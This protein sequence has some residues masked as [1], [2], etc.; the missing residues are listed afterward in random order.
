MPRVPE[1]YDDLE[2][3][4]K[5]PAPFTRE[6]TVG[7]AS[8]RLYLGDVNAK[9]FD[10]ALQEWIDHAE[11]VNARRVTGG[12]TTPKRAASTSSASSTRDV[13][14]REQTARIRE[15]AQQQEFDPPVSDNGRLR[16][17][18]IKAYFASHPDDTPVNPAHAAI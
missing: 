12:G 9:R 17:E 1:D 13:L 7:G 2:W 3:P 10:E 16:R 5:V 6:F 4:E 14:E 11:T 15:W 8:Y 18:V